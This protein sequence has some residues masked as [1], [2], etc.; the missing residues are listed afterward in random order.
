MSA[1]QTDKVALQHQSLVN[2]VF[3]AVGEVSAAAEGRAV[4]GERSRL[5]A[6]LGISVDPDVVRG[7]KQD[8]VDAWRHLRCEV[9]AVEV[10]LARLREGGA[11]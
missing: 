4:V 9:E 8:Y 11:R 3:V 2:R 6:T 10:E 1:P 5:A 7:S